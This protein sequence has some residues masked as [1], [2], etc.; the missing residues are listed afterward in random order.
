M[1]RLFSCLLLGAICIFSNSSCK[2]TLESAVNCTGESLLVS[3]H[4]NA[5][6]TSPKLVHVE[7]QYSGS[8]NFQSVTWD[9]GDGNTSTVTTKTADHTYATSG[10]FRVKG[11][12]KIA[13]GSSSCESEHSKSVDI[14]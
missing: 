3:I 11:K 6:A 2:K 9:F 7:V 8:Y 10:T 1:K 14:K 5:D 13:S 12:V 4:V